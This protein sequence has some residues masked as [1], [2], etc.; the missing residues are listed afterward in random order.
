MPYP[1]DLTTSRR[2]Q[3]VVR[4]LL[5]GR[6]HTTL[7]IVRAS[8]QCAVDTAIRE[9]RGAPNGLEITR[10]PASL[11]DAE[12]RKRVVHYYR[13]ADQSRRMLLEREAQRLADEASRIGRHEEESE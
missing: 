4:V 12:G 2:L 6:E 1:C 11:A 3:A 10:R 13:L 5:D 7:D 9:L 8:G